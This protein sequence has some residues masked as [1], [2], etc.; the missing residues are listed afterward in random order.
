MMTYPVWIDG[1]LSVVKVIQ[2][3]EFQKRV[4]LRG[5]GPEFSSFGETICQFFDDF[6]ADGLLARSP[7][8]SGLSEI[9]YAKLKEFCDRLSEYSG[10]TQKFPVPADILA[11][12]RWLGICLM[13]GHVL[14]AFKISP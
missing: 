10:Q 2:D 8:E 13:A 12:P 3:V 7:K 5:E 14:D 4:W 6:D 9:Q 11:D 1:V